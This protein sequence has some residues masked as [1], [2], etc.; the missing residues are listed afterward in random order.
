MEDYESHKTQIKCVYLDVAT[1]VADRTRLAI[2]TPSALVAWGLFPSKSVTIVYSA[3]DDLPYI[4]YKGSVNMTTKG[5]LRY[6]RVCRVHI[7][8]AYMF[9]KK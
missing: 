8:I 3:G 2:S 7:G 5:N 1:F 9:T 4:G 6:R